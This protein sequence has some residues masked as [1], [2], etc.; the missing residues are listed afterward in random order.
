MTEIEKDGISIKCNIKMDP[1]PTDSTHYDIGQ[2]KT[3]K[4]MT[5]LCHRQAKRRL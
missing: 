2:L 1:K 5:Q 4:K 3:I